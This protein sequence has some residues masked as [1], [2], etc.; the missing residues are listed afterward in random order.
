MST[1][2]REHSSSSQPTNR[3]KRSRPGRA[4]AIRADPPVRSPRSCRVTRWPSSAATRAASRPATPPPRTV[5]AGPSPPTPAPSTGTGA[6]SVS[7]PV[8]GST[9]QVT[10]GLR[11]S[12]T[13]Q[14]WLHSTQGRI[15]S[16]CP[17]RTLATRSASA[18]CARVI[19]TASAMPSA[20]ARSAIS[21]ST[22]EP[23]A[24]TTTRSPATARTAS[25]IERVSSR[26][27]PGA[28]WPSGRVAPAEKI[29]PR[30]TVS[31]STIGA[32]ES[33]STSAGA[34]SVAISGVMPA[35][36][37]S[38]SQLRRSPTTRSAPTAS[39]TAASTRRA[40]RVR[41]SPHSSPRVLV[42]PD[43]NWRTRENWPALTSTPSQPATT[44]RRAASANPSTTAAMSSASIS[45]GTSRVFTSGTRPGAHSSRW[46]QCEV[47]WPPAWPSP[48]S[49]TV[50]WGRHASTTADQ[51]GPHSSASGA[52]SSGQ[53]DGCTEASSVTITPAPPRARRP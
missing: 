35:Q 18:S 29:E 42:N 16:G 43:R 37:A 31:R 51:P 44:A 40:N 50:P 13:W 45:L 52:R 12:R 34:S 3:S 10:I 25:R 2:R 15:R 24:A 20:T 32:P 22:I 23:C 1:P 21:T 5:T 26:L 17:A 38:S 11:L 19:S 9:T 46:D 47:P 48:A 36:G 53:S 8:V 14:V 28:V 49:T 39:R 27:N 6:S 33:S 30:T 7:C 41:S 4:A